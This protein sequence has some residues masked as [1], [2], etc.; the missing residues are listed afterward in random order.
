MDRTCPTIKCQQLNASLHKWMG[1]KC[2][3]VHIPAAFK[4]ID[5]AK[6][7]EY[8]INFWKTAENGPYSKYMNDVFQAVKGS[9]YQVEFKGPG[10]CELRP[11]PLI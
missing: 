8:L 10:P 3:R 5:K 11:D 2:V 9:G 1:G 6:V 7:I 4:Y